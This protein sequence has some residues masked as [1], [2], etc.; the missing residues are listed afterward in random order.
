MRWYEEEAAMAAS[1]RERNSECKKSGAWSDLAE[2]FIISIMERLHGTDRIRV[3]AV[4]KNWNVIVKS[5]TGYAIDKIDKLPWTMQYKWRNPKSWRNDWSSCKIYEPKCHHDRALSYL[6][7]KGRIR[8][9]TSFRDVTICAARDGWVLSRAKCEFGGEL[10]LFNPFTKRV[11]YLPSEGSSFS[12]D[13]CTFSFAPNSADSNYL[14]FAPHR[15]S[16]EVYVEVYSSA[17]KE[18][19]IYNPQ[20]DDIGY[21]TNVWYMEEEGKFYCHFS[22]FHVLVFDINSINGGEDPII[23]F[24]TTCPPKS[25]YESSPSPDYLLGCDGDLYLVFFRVYS[26]SLSVWKLDWE[27]KEWV[28]VSTLEGRAMFLG[29]ASFCVSAG[30]ETEI[31]ANRIYYYHSGYPYFR[32]LDGDW[33]GY[34][35]EYEDESPDPIPDSPDSS[36]SN[37]TSER[38]AG[39]REKMTAKIYGCCRQSREIIWI[40]PPITF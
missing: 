18:W 37:C 39:K 4:C 15:S 38:D 11:I 20:I 33:D 32:Y 35:D 27:G 36:D 30:G 24:T 16:G 10:F 23:F 34:Q 28:I 22:T 19:K 2:D 9:R 31:V 5:S 6:V 29:A 25:P 26:G 8:G 13:C 14:V 7:E 1:G 40:Q 12:G 3:G 17:D 21:P